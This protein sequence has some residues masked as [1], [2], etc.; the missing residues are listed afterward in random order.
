MS[1]S[2]F[3]DYDELAFGPLFTTRD[4]LQQ[5]MDDYAE[6][7]SEEYDAECYNF[8]AYDPTLWRPSFDEIENAYAMHT[9]YVTWMKQAKMYMQLGNQPNVE[10][11]QR[12]ARLEVS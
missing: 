3:T 9:M 11:F 8:R 1:E 12:L 4:Q 5:Y 7:R 2:L 6:L 10:Y